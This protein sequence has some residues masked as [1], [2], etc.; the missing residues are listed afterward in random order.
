MTEKIFEY[1]VVASGGKWQK[2][3]KRLSYFTAETVPKLHEWLK[4]DSE[5]F[6]S[7]FCFEN[8]KPEPPLPTG[9]LTEVA[10]TTEQTA[11]VQAEKKGCG[12]GKKQAETAVADYSKH[13]DDDCFQCAEK[14]IGTAY[15][16]YAKEA[17]YKELNRLQ[18]IGELNNAF[19]H[20]Y[21][22]NPQFAEKLRDLRHDIQLRKDVSD[23]R[24]Q[25]LA[26]ELDFIQKQFDEIYIFSN[27]PAESKLL[28]NDAALMVFLNT[29]APAD[30]YTDHAHR[31]VF[32]RADKA[33]YGEV[34]SDMPNFYIFGNG[35]IGN[36][37]IQRIKADYDWNYIIEEGKVKS[38]STGYT[39]ALHLQ[40]K[41][42]DATINLVNFGY[43]V[44]KSTYRCPWHN[45]KFEDAKLQQFNHIILE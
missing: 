21:G 11:I 39:V 16:L 9:T 32:H 19:N 40:K 5:S 42:P 27:V 10:L 41:Y 3:G 15:A 13:P 38:C 30:K 24:W 23:E 25:Q 14:H 26:L 18:Y 37:E 22:V 20:L 17:G 2:K 34:R 45:W 28:V 44:Q 33:D 1:R 6:A 7:Y 36:A 31:C 29:A 35:G 43:E 8:E 4:R 12:C